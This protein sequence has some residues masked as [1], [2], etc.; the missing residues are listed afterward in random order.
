MGVTGTVLGDRRR[1]LRICGSDRSQIGFIG[2]IKA[3]QWK[4]PLFWTD[5]GNDYFYSFLCASYCSA[6]IAV[7]NC[8]RKKWMQC[9]VFV[10]VSVR[11]LS[12][13]S[14]TYDFLLNPIP[15]IIR[16]KWGL[17]GSLDELIKFTVNLWSHGVTDE[18]KVFYI[19]TSI[20]RSLFLSILCIHNLIMHMLQ[21][22]HR[23]LK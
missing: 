4:Y 15:I 3:V 23:R 20:V 17:P 21:Y 11:Y 12:N 14:A 10:W 9:T 8:N 13:W 18:Q 7:F 22:S 16:P 5:F 1:L 6:M 19:N 2:R